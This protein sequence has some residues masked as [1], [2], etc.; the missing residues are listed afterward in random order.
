MVEALKIPAHQPTSVGAMLKEEFL[1]PLGITQGELAQ[2]MGVGRKTVNELCMD[3][4]G[5]TAETA[6]LLAKVLGTTPEFWLNLQV[7]NDMWI[8]QHNEVL[9]DK[10]EHARPL[11]A[12]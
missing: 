11:V 5:V 4:R 9:A 3:R 6:F 1:E 7:I 8:A 10:L 12:A 2:A